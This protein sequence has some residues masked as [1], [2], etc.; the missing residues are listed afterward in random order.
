MML[1]HDDKKRQSS[2]IMMTKE[3]ESPVE[4]SDTYGTFRL[5]LE[6]SSAK[7]ISGR[8]PVKLGGANT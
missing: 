5:L 8:G 1:L 4:A 2:Y 7:K 6:S 3:I